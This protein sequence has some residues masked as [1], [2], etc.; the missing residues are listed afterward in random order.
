MIRDYKI[1]VS[2]EQISNIISKIKDYPWS[3]IENMEG[4]THGTNK[5]YLK[6]LCEYWTSDFDWKKHE[7]LINSFSNFKTNVDGIDIHFIQEKGSGENPKPL[8]LMHGWPGS[9][10]E[11]LEIIR[12]LAHPEEFGGNEEDAFTVIA[13]SLPGFGF[14]GSSKKPIGPRK[15]AEILNKL[16]TDNLNHKQYVAQGGDWGATIA[17]WL[18]YDH[19]INCK[20]I[21]I[22]CLTMR[23]PDGPQTD[24]E[25]KWQNK[26]DKDQIIQDGYRTQQ[27]TKP[28]T[29]SYSMIDSPVGIAAWIT[30]KMHG[31]SDLKDNNIESVY[32]KDVLL[33][34]IMVYVLTNTFN[35]ASW[36]YFGRREEGGRYFPK[37]FKKINIPTGISMFPKEMSEWP[38]STYIERI[39]NV[40]HLSKMNSGGHFPAL[41]NPKILVKDIN[42]FFKKISL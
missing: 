34:N 10:V 29:L 14:S 28:Q 39:F 23:H 33:A 19:H 13:P 38:P 30:E 4:W 27:A 41:E 3:S 9:I 8:L 6:E 36:I 20:A 7:N 24:E 26:F 25:K 1:N 12:P 17:N 35:T 22:N 18:G 15:I 11:F 5:E 32:S 16:M 31:W 42:L 21:H 2:N 40:Q 37:D